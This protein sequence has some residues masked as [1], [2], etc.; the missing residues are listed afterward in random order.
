VRSDGV[1]VMTLLL[2]GLL[3]DETGAPML[4]T[5]TVKGQSRRYRSY[6]SKPAMK[7]EASKAAISRIPAPPLEELPS[8]V[9]RRLDLQ[10][11]APRK[12]FVRFLSAPCRRCFR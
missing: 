7:G 4:P 9:L 6:V 10:P 8:S 11:D 5:Y 2:A 12:C 1:V 3:F